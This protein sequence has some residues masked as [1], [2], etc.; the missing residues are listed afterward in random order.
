[1]GGGNTD[2][3]MQVLTLADGLL[4]IHSAVSILILCTF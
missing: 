1:M 3:I 4:S 2:K